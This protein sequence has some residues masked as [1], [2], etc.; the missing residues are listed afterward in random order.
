M[1][2]VFPGRTTAPFRFGLCRDT[3]Q[4]PWRL[5]GLDDTGRPFAAH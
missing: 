1:R 3:D 5:F 4:S 2:F